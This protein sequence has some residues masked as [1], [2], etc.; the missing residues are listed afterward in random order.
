MQLKAFKQQIHPRPWVA[1]IIFA[2]YWNITNHDEGSDNDDENDKTLLWNDW[3]TKDQVALSL[4]VT[5]AGDSQLHKPLTRP[6]QIK[7]CAELSALLEV[8][9]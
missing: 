9:Q 4:V 7:N 5:V 3:P 2:V 6:E 1:E 8:V